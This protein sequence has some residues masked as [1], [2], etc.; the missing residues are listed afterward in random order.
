MQIDWL[1]ILIILLLL[2]Y[3][4]SLQPRLQHIVDHVTANNRSCNP[5]WTLSGEGRI[6]GRFAYK[7]CIH[8]LRDKTDSYESILYVNFHVFMLRNNLFKRIIPVSRERVMERTKVV[9]GHL[10]ST[11]RIEDV[12]KSG[13]RR[14]T[15][16]TVRHG[17][18]DRPEDIVV[19]C[20]VRTPIGKAKRGSFKV[21]IRICIE[22]F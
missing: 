4:K 15:F 16:D 5:D 19:V 14:V 7:V 11:L 20:A 12:S 8:S 2:F 6:L 9:F 18:V 1:L 10:Q 13:T 21:I 17:A 22:I 3:G